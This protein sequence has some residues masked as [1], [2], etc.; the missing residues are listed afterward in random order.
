MAKVDYI[1]RE[2]GHNLLRNISL[3]LASMVTVAVSLS[4]VGSALLLRQGVQNATA[5]WE[6]GIEFI[7]FVNADASGE[8]IQAL[9]EA[10]SESPAIE[11]HTYVDQEAAYD[12]FREMFSRTPE[13][14][15]AVE[16]DILP[17]SFRVVPTNPDAA[18]IRAVGEQFDD[19]P[20]VFR[21]VFAFDTVQQV[22]RLSR[23][24]SI[25]ILF[26]AGVLLLAAGLLI[27]NT[28]RMAM[29]ARRREIEVMKLVGAT[30]WFIRVPFMLEGLIQGIVGA[31]VAVGSV[32]V[33]NNFFESRLSGSGDSFAIL[34]GFA[35]SSGEVFGTSLFVLGVGIFVGVIGSGIAV[36][37]YLD[38]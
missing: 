23:V 29:F 7:V 6:G 21:V 36:S 37:R 33:L 34:Q 16:P 38:V 13:M 10:L 35:V 28:I 4:L 27:L 26:V 20:G 19:Q 11:S 8:Q 15:E 14:I 25:G 24:L 22:Q 3:T 2:T 18:A 32:V 9:N 17:S 30:N 12:E 1:A 31:A 5:R